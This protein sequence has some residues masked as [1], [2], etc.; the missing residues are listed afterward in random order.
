MSHDGARLVVSFEEKGPPESMEEIESR[1][2]WAYYR[3]LLDELLPGSFMLSSDRVGIS[4]FHRE[5]DFKMS[6]MIEV[7]QKLGD[8]E[9]RPSLAPI[10][11]M[12]GMSDRHN[13]RSTTTSISPDTSRSC[14]ASLP[15]SRK[16]PRCSHKS[17]T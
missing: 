9:V 5:L 16:P 11:F 2:A 1:T 4:L 13:T 8:D 14:A 10:L 3:F 7:L 12:T 17:G 15:D 6:E